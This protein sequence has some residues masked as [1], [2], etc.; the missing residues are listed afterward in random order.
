MVFHEARKTYGIASYRHG[1]N[2]TVRR[3][4]NACLENRYA[5]IDS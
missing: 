5:T 2:L 1:R 3:H 4:S